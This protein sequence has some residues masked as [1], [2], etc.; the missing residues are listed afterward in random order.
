MGAF[1]T[2]ALDSSN[3]PVHIDAVPTGSA[4]QCHCPHCNAPLD[5][6]NA[7]SIR[8]HHFAHAHGHQCEGAYESQIHMLAKQVIIEEGGIMLPASSDKN[9]PSGFV[10][11]S[12]VEYEKWDNEYL[13]RPDVEGIMEDGRRLLIECFV[14]HK[15]SEK[16]YRTIID[17]NLLCIEINLNWLEVDKEVLRNFLTQESDDR[18]WIILREQKIATGLGSAYSKNPR[19]DKARDILKAAF[20]NNK[21][22]IEQLIDHTNYSGLYYYRNIEHKPYLLSQYGYDVCEVD[23]RFRGF[24]TDLLLYRSGKEDKG[25]ISINFRGRRRNR[26]GRLPKDLRIIDIIIREE[27]DEILQERFSRGVLSPYEN[28]IEFLGCWKI[29]K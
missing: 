23:T 8:E 19:Y 20:D 24:K 15:V 10:K 27:S 21:M 22:A 14:T 16:K 7:G 6:K 5:A 13:F 18:K 12:N 29:N 2:H 11:L 3:L 25:Y 9:K 17:N 4:C 1:L 26:G 28:N